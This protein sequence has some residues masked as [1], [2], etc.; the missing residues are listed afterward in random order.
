[1]F[2][3]EIYDAYDTR[4]AHYAHVFAHTVSTALIDC[5]EVVGLVERRAHHL[6]RYGAILSHHALLHTLHSG[7]VLLRLAYLFGKHFHLAFEIHIALGE[8]TVDVGEREIL[9]H[10]RAPLVHLAADGVG[11]CEPYAALIAVVMKQQREA[12]HLKQHEDKPVVV[13]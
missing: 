7:S 1:M 13:A 2:G 4:S 12:Q 6:G 3:R 9:G 8:L 11:R 10:S 5:D